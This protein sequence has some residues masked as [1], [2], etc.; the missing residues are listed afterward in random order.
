LLAALTS[1]PRTQV[2]SDGESTQLTG[3][4][5]ANYQNRGETDEDTAQMPRVIQL[6]VSWAESGSQT[7]KQGVE[8]RPNRGMPFPK[9]DIRDPEDLFIRACGECVIPRLHRP[10]KG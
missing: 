2:E 7:G 1:N 10:E 9:A 4:N 3:G 5:D 8:E 6:H